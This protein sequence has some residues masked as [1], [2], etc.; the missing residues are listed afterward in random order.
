MKNEALNELAKTLT[1]EIKGLPFENARI[2]IEEH[3]MRTIWHIN[4]EKNI[5]IRIELYAD[6]DLSLRKT[7]TYLGSEPGCRSHEHYRGDILDDDRSKVNQDAIQLVLLLI[8][9]YKHLRS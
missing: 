6:G 2:E 8:A 4:P 9:Q 7:E 3:P 5:W 1:G